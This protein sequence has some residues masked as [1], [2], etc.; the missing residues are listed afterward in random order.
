MTP[1]QGPRPSTRGR[2]RWRMV[3]LT[4]QQVE[5]GTMGQ[6]LSPSPLLPREENPGVLEASERPEGDDM[7]GGWW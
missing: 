2:R 3:R 4:Q 7:G 1:R 6:V 5:A